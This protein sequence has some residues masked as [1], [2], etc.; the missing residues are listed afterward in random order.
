MTIVTI[1]T[2]LMILMIMRFRGGEPA[3]AGGKSEGKVP[4]S[5]PELQYL[6]LWV[7]RT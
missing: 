7:A 6:T 2:I 5:F 3:R 4:R 1:V